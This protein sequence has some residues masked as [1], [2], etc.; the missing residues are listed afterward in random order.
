MGEGSHG[1]SVEEFAKVVEKML[2]Q[3]NRLVG[4][5]KGEEGGQEEGDVEG[6]ETEEEGE[7]GEEEDEKGEKEAGEE[8]SRGKGR[9]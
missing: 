7:E 5:R 4:R 2:P 3:R 1:N 8:R 9:K 6:G